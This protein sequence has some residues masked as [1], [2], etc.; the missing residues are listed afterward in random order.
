MHWKL[1]LIYMQ[2][3]ILVYNLFR[4]VLSVFK[5]LDAGVFT[6]GILFFLRGERG[7]TKTLP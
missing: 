2:R 4:T 7:V 3:R 5:I 1:H 6:V